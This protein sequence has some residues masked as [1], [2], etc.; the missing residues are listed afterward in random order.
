MG[1]PGALGG[2]KPPQC[3][4]PLLDAQL[5][6]WAA[7]HDADPVTRAQDV[8]AAWPVRQ[9]ATEH[10]FASVPPTQ[11]PGDGDGDGDG[12]DVWHTVRIAGGQI[13]DLDDVPP[14]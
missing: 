2:A 13:V 4:T 11:R 5:D 7:A 10:D 1:C 8:P 9:A 3:L 14:F 6:R 12:Q